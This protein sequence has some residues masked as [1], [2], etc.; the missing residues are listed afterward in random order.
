M[1]Y[2]LCL[3]LLLAAC[4]HKKPASGCHGNGDCDAGQVCKQGGCADLCND[5]ISCASGKICD[6]GTCTTGSRGSPEI[7]GVTSNGPADG[8]PGHAAV[9]L[10]DQLIVSGKNL[11]GAQIALNIDGAS[12]P[13]DICEQSADGVTLSL[14]VTLAEGT[15]TL[16]ATNQAGCA[17]AEVP[18]LQ[19]IQGD[20]GDTG[21]TGPLPTVA[22]GFGLTGDGTQQNPLGVAYLLNLVPDGSLEN[23]PVTSAFWRQNG[24]QDV[25]V[26]RDLDD[27]VKH[28]GARSVR[29]V[30]PQ[31]VTSSVA[32]ESDRI[33]VRPGVRVRFAA[34]GRGENIHQ[35]LLA[36]DTLG[37]IGKFLDDTDTVLAADGTIELT[38]DCDTL[39]DFEWTEQS[40]ELTVPDGARYFRVTSA[41]ILDAGFGTAWL[42]DIRLEAAY[43]DIGLMG[44]PC[45]DGLVRITD[46]VVGTYCID[47]SS[48]TATGAYNAQ[49]AC[50]DL[51]RRVCLVP[52]YTAAYA[53][54][55]LLAPT[56]AQG[57]WGGFLALYVG[58]ANDG[59]ACTG[60][61]MWARDMTA[62]DAPVTLDCVDADRTGGD[63]ACP[64]GA[65][66]CA[67]YRCCK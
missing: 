29:F 36:T 4:S 40:M 49:Q 33:P 18:I 42:D 60:P 14:P 52:E 48:H 41:G 38:W 27:T 11:E 54:G 25:G 35:G 6:D 23:S 45:P 3:T 24:S 37:V 66:K 50:A 1:R 47:K 9:H 19:G 51:G 39:H 15:Y 17:S 30:H 26:E 2:L 56:D 65:D 5:D 67:Q 63:P 22:E 34:W 55:R 16:S 43:A 10:G 7:Q 58:N 32:I 8:A 12:V 61:T 13:F 62:P 44:D 57:E 28:N 53:Q 59:A 21:N 64:G 46:Q 31:T 20:K